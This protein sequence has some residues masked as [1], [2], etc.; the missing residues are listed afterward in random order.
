MCQGKESS[1]GGW[2]VGGGSVAKGVVKRKKN[3]D[4][5]P[6]GYKCQACQ[7]SNL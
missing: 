3:S 7:G 2:G 5:R 4:H 6:G 1:E